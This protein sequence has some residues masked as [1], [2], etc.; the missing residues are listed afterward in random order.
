MLPGNY[1]PDHAAAISID[2]GETLT[3]GQLEDAS[4]RLSHVLFDAGLRPGDVVALVT[5]NNLRAFE[6]YWAALRSG[7]YVTAVNHH[8]S[9]EEVAYIVNDSGARA[10][11]ASAAKAELAQAVTPLTPEVGLRL[12]FGGDIATFTSYT[13]A[14][15]VASSVPFERQPHGMPM[16]Y[17]S[18]TTGCPK[19]VR[20]ALPDGEITVVRDAMTALLG[21]HFG[22]G[23]D[24]KYLSPAP[25]YHAAPLRWC[26]AVQSFGGTVLVTKKFDA[27]TA[28]R[29]IEQFGVTHAQFVPTMFVRML[30]LP[31]SNRRRFDTSSLR[32]AVHAAAPCPVEVKQQMI[33]WWGPIL[34]EY[35]AG[36]ESNG[37]TIIDSATWLT[38]PGT[39][40]KAAIGVLHICD[41]DGR[42]LG[43]GEVGTVYV[44]RD[45]EVFRYHNDP[46]KTRAAQHPDHPLWTT[47]GD[48]GYV[49]D[50]GYLFL[51]DR[52]AFMIISGGVNIY[53]QET[54]NALTLHPAVFDVAVIGLPDAE[55]GETV[56]AF[57]QPNAGVQPTDA[58]GEE[59]IS[60]VKSKIAA[61]KAPRVVRFVDSLPRTETGKL[62]KR[63]LKDQYSTTAGVPA[64]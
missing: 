56:T 1:A 11:V 46:E 5:D 24:T 7:L 20:P 40:G 26:T 60:F 14:L 52:K 53:P 17:S 30:Q 44:E 25:L 51:T 36:T 13:D 32:V 64:P 61:F 3:Y 37:M 58:L 12:S 27:E 39:V 43:S 31:E 49:D 55:M 48:I 15:A 6:V 35:Y 47:L 62:V 9:A 38:K 41:D 45:V 57:V 23:P 59:L 28:L 22:F 8:L 33:D 4:V 16:L 2:T 50:E 21:T 42:E 29:V 18:G 10:V 34:V 19:G 63:V 54:E